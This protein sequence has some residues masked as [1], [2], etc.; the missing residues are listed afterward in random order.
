VW[1]VDP[2]SR[3][4]RAASGI[5][6]P[7]RDP[8]RRAPQLLSHDGRGAVSCDV[9]QAK[10]PSP[11]LRQPI[12]CPGDML[13]TSPSSVYSRRCFEATPRKRILARG[14]GALRLGRGRV[15]AVCALVLACVLA[16]SE[17][18]AP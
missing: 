4:A 17:A 6:G 14:A 1:S 13:A 9:V 10:S 15:Q 5:Q 12:I 16:A 7:G 3:V 18:P 11:E 8:V 2:E